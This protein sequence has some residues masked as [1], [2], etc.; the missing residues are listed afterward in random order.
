M[1]RRDVDGRADTGLV[2][3]KGRGM[4]SR[5]EAAEYVRWSLGRNLLQARL[6]G[7]LTQQ[8]L[9]RKIGKAQSTVSMSEKGQ[10]S[11]SRDYV[12]AVLRACGVPRNWNRKM[13]KEWRV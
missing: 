1:S 11:V 9:A 3:A 10:I 7:D 6:A 12:L 2:V 13:W 5:N 4:L 8:E